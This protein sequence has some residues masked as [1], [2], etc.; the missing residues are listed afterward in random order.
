MK[1]IFLILL[2]ALVSIVAYANEKNEINYVITNADT[3]ICKEMSMGFSNA[4]I[5][6][7]NG[8]VVKVNKEDVDA[9]K[10]NGKLYERKVVFK[11]KNATGV[12]AHME[13]ISQ[14]NGL[15]LYCYKFIADS[16]WDTKKG[17]FEDAREVASL[18]VYKDDN[19]YLE[20]DEQNVPTILD[21]FHVTGV[22]FE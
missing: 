8:D 13:L 14:R 5:T 15:K 21:F 6:K 18:L 10:V 1:P 3:I 7:T 2:T 9:Y 16:G 4:E 11:N 17:N 22:Q 20:V 19:L 12:R